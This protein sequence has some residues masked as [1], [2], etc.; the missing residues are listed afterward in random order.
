MRRKRDPRKKRGP[1]RIAKRL[2]RDANRRGREVE[3]ER[4]EGREGRNEE[5]WTP[6]WREQ[7]DATRV[8]S[9]TAT[10]E[11]NCS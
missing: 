2:R 6:N 9:V 11:R 5:R 10:P 8:M 3:R 1:S 4:I 7:I